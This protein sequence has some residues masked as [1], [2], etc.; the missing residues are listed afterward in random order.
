[1]GFIYSIQNCE[2]S[3]QTFRPSHQKCPTCPMI[4]VNTE[5]LKFDCNFVWDEHLIWAL[6]PHYGDVIMNVIVPQI[7]SVLIVNST[8]CSGA[9][10]RKHQSSVSL[11]FVRGIH[12]WP[13]NSPPQGTVM[14]KMFP[15]DD[16][17]MCDWTINPIIQKI[18]KFD[19]NFV[20]DEH[21]IWALVPHY[22][23]VIM[24]VIVPQITGVLTV[25]STICSGADQR[26]HQ[27]SVS[28]AFVRGIHWW[29]MNSPPQGT[30][31]QKMF[32]FDDVIMKKSHKLQ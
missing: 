10:Q 26:N 13:M 15:F 25:Y 3:H 28:L 16:V 20:W 19:C 14:Q 24:N 5:M 29:P 30:V 8:I 4:F 32:P 22:S 12:W 18:L 27:S 7:T 2:I 23:D 1:M 17:I 6:V 31:M 21:L 9:D 11:A